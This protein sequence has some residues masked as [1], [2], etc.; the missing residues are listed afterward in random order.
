MDFNVIRQNVS[1]NEILFEGTV[2]QP[3]D[4]DITLPDYCPDIIRILKCIITPCVTQTN[5][6]GNRATIDGNAVIRLIY[7]CE[8]GKIK[9]YEQTLPYSKYAEINCDS[10]KPCIRVRAKTDYVN[11]RAVNQRRVDIHASVVFDVKVT[12]IKSEEMV[13]GADGAG[14]QLKHKNIS[15]NELVGEVEQPFCVSEVLEVGSSKSPVSQIIRCNATAIIKE[16]KAVSNKLLLKGELLVKTLYC[17]TDDGVELIE[18]SVP[19]SQIIEIEGIDDTCSNEICLK[20]SNIEACPKSDSNNEM[21]LIEITARVCASVYST[22]KTQ[23][24][25]IEDAYSTKCELSLESKTKSFEVLDESFSDTYLNRTGIELSG[26]EITKVIDLWCIDVTAKAAMNSGSFCISGVTT[27]AML[28]IDADGQP[29]YIERQADYEYRRDVKLSGENMRCSPNVYI[30]A[31]DYVL[32]ASNK[33]DVRLEMNIEA[34]VYT[35]HSEQLVSS[36]SPD[37]EKIKK[38]N[39]ALLTVYYSESGESVWNIAR[40]YNTTVEAV[41]SENKLAADVI[42]EKKMLLIPGV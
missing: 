19:F 18:H 14:I 20:V 41:M 6:T 27:V 13:S 36:I 12:G 8:G 9:C 2:E 15:V 28:A 23:M 35:V 29:V 16:Q 24:P 3:I 25:I 32:S 42:E 4:T 33:I 37:E 1:G 17:S 22:R 26:M 40:R 34:S 39:G 5:L 10:V 21:R 11:C 31:S 7:S 38:S 30:S